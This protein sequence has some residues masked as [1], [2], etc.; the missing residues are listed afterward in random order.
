MQWDPDQYR[1]FAP[2]RRQ[3]A[4]DLLARVPLAAP[5]RV[6]DLG[7]GPGDI[8]FELVSRWPAAALI[9]VDDSESMLSRATG[10]K[11]WGPYLQRLDFGEFAISWNLNTR[12]AWQRADIADWEPAPG[13][14]P[15]L[16]FSNAALHWLPEHAALLPRLLS[17]LAPGG[18]L[19]V[20]M[21]RSWGLSS[22]RLMRETLDEGGV[23]GA[24]LGSPGLR[25]QMAR[26]PVGE[27]TDYQALLAPRC[28]SLDI[29]ETVYMQIL[30][31]EDPVLEWVKGSVLRPVLEGLE[32]ADRRRFLEV[33]RERLRMAYPARADGGVP[34]PFPRLFIVA[35]V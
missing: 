26:K 25:E 30:T 34:F 28:R 11:K 16:I 19:A 17:M 32:P 31:G 1:R 4:L 14:A 35:T 33:Y 8:T 15:D 29:W 7:C 13:E 20:Q 2:L 5:Q 9:G 27:A 21:P 10:G 22:H 3:P 23:G 18:C 12:V 6:V 24:A